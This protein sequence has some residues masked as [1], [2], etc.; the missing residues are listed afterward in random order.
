MPLILKVLFFN[1]MNLLPQP[2]SN[3]QEVLLTLIKKGKVSIKDFPYLSGFRTRVSE[4]VLD[5]SLVLR[6]EYVTVKNKFNRSIT[7]VEHHLDEKHIDTAIA[8]Y[9]RLNN[10]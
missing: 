3:K 8:I 9:N 1:D 4:L 10:L 6:N 5:N 2:K 7:Y